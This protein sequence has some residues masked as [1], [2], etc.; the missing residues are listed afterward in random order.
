VDGLGDREDLQIV[1][2]RFYRRDKEADRLRR[3]VQRGA[4]QC[5][6]VEKG[7]IDPSSGLSGVSAVADDV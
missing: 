2:P 3:I 7:D 6:T 4:G 5:F 1:S